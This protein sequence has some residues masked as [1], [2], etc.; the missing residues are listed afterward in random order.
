MAIILS[1]FATR[2]Q[3]IATSD[4]AG[5][6]V[7][8][9]FFVDLKAGDLL[10][11]NTIDLGVLPAGHTVHSAILIPD[12]LDTGTTITIDV[13]LMSG[14]VGENNA[15]RTVGTELFA[16]STAAQTGTPVSAATTKSAHTI[17]P[18]GFDRSIG[19]K[20]VTAPTGATAGR[21]RLSLSTYAAN[22]GMTY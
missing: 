22:S 21:L 2:Q 6:L 8:N 5:N 15:A 19:A 13:G 18:V 16:A 4:S 12:D 3:R 11:G 7:V 17:V 1:Q 10:A 20:I 14:V 9:P